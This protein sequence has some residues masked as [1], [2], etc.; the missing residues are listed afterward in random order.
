MQ[1]RAEERQ[2]QIEELRRQR[3]STPVYASPVGRG[4]YYQPGPYG[5]PYG[6]PFGGQSYGRQYYAAPPGD[7]YN[8]YGGY[9]SYDRYGRRRQNNGFGGGGLGL[10]I[11]GGLAG[12][13]LLGDL[14]GGGFF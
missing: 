2:R 5:Q 11:L 12:G 10:P 4:R 1:R 9:E 3:L 13:L 7:P 6:Q 14:I 8:C